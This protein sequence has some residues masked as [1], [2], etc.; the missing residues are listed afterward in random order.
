VPIPAPQP[1]FGPGDSTSPFAAPPRAKRPGGLTAIC[2]IAIVL[3]ALGVPSSLSTLASVAFGQATS[4]A[5]VMPEQP[6]VNGE[7]VKTNEKFQQRVDEVSR[8]FRGANIGLAL[9]NLVVSV[10]LLVGAILML[11]MNVTARRFLVAV[12]AVA[13][14]FEIVHTCIF[15]FIQLQMAPVLAES[16]PRMMKSTVPKGQPGAEQAAEIGGII[17]KLAVFG[18]IAFHVARGLAELIYYA[19]AARYLCKPRIRALCE[20]VENTG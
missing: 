16:M 7:F 4:K 12:L 3:G 9:M 6:G 19:V 10:G 8:R 18:G 14:V 1:P 15:V 11:K 5:F 20:P 17:A 13:I 2:V